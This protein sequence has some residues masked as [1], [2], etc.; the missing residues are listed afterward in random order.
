MAYIENVV[1]P[2]KDIQIQTREAFD[3][4]DKLLDQSPAFGRANPQAI[5][6]FKKMRK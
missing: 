5:N 3:F 6:Q 4:L 2:S 1:D